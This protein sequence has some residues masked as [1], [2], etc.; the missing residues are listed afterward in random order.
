MSRIDTVIWTATLAGVPL[1]TFQTG[2]GGE[3]SATG[4]KAW[5]GGTGEVERGGRKGQSNITLTRENDGNPTAAWLRGQI[6]AA[7]KIHRTPADDTGNPRMAEQVE[8]TGRLLRV[9]LSD[10]DRMDE[11]AVEMVTLEFGLDA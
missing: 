5:N 2:A 8:F 11:G 9:A 4:H 10:A 7:A 6:N 3:L 1:G